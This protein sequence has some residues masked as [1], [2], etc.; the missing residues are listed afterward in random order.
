MEKPQRLIR[1]YAFPGFRPMATVN[2]HPDRPDTM[3]ITLQRR[4]KKLPAD[5]AELF[6]MPFTTAREGSFGIYHAPRWIS[7]L[8]S[9]SDESSAGR[10]GK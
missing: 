9:R 10:A 7:T 5:V 4:Q 8:M 3:V 2:K 1:Q 6:I